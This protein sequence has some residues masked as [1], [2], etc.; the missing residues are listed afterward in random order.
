MTRAYICMKISK[1]PP[2]SGP[3][4]YKL[5]A[6]GNPS[7][8]RVRLTQRDFAFNKYRKHP[9]VKHPRIIFHIGM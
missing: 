7:M 3:W 8:Q 9:G 2:G 5:L 1:Y 6:D 4:L